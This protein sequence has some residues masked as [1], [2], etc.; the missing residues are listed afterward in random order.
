MKKKVKLEYGELGMAN[1]MII[2]YGHEVD[3][4]HYLGQVFGD[5]YQF[6]D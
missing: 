3:Q 5:P 1:P 4:K 2:S 6:N